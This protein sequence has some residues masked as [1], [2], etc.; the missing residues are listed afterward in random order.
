LTFHSNNARYDATPEAALET[1]RTFDGTALLD[2]DE[3][4]YLRNSTEDFIDTARPAILALLL[5]R[6]LEVLRPW[7]WTGG[8]ATRDVWRVHLVLVLF[9]W[10][11]ALWRARVRRLAAE[12]ANAP[13][14]EASGKG[15]RPRVV[16][17]VGF[18]PVV[19][20]HVAALG[21]AP[22]RVVAART[23]SFEDRRAGKLRLAV[24]A[25]GAHVV[26]QSAVLTDSPADLPLLDVCA[27]PLRV[28]W[29]G[30][31]YRPALSAVYVPGRYLTRVKRPN[32]RYISRGILQEDFAIWVLTSIA[33]AALPATHL[34]GLL[35][36]LLS[37]WAIYEQ[38]YVDNDTV[39]ARHETDP[40]LSAAFGRTDVGTPRLAPWGW[41]LLS[42]AAGIILLRWPAAPAATD[43]ASWSAVL[44]AT[45][46]WFLIYNR[47]DKATRVWLFGGLQLARGAAF[48]VL[49]PIVPIAPAAIGAHVLSKWVPYLMYRKGGGWPEIPLHL[50]RL[51]FF[52]IL[53]VILA[54]AEGPLELADWSAAALLGFM[55][56]K[57]RRELAAA[58][59]AAT[60]LDRDAA[61]RQSGG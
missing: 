9:P 29:P 54:F 2:L 18:R 34:L 36:L 22:A 26:R 16:A 15:G 11:L 17:T 45:W 5:L 21:L 61:D 13:L 31:R 53:T 60:R 57:A 38:G 32:A 50:I 7:R 14:I 41:A 4:L 49:V 55:L 35:A 40:Q 1:L 44:L 3:T 51:L 42:G 24:N 27:L 20:P 8:E 33:L 56:F 6:L 12:H 43:L 19:L 25:L 48:A 58:S 37:F 30:A 28:V 46:L 39:A 23:W 59:R 10:T 52:V 47:L